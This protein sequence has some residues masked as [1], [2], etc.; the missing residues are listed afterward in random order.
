MSHYKALAKI[1]YLNHVE[2][3]EDIPGLRKAFPFLESLSSG[4]VARLWS[5]FCEQEVSAGWLTPDWLDDL[6]PDD[7]YRRDVFVRWLG[8]YGDDE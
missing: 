4:E 2:Y 8:D 5:A 6:G 3:P 7:T 1:A